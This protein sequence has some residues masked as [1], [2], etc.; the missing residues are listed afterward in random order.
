M[1]TRR[2]RDVLNESRTLFFRIG[3]PMIRTI[4]WRP[5]PE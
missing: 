2:V 4:V 1:N 3:F 5:I